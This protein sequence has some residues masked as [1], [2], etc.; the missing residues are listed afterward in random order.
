VAD[1]V[2]VGGRGGGR[3]GRG[4]GRRR[5][6]GLPIVAASSHLLGSIHGPDLGLP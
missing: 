3:E 4:E 6:R 1:D 5:R 2:V